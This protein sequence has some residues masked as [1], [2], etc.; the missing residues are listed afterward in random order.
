MATWH[1]EF[2]PEVITNRLEKN[3]TMDAN[4]QVSFHGFEHSEYT[5][6]L[7]SMINFNREIPELER[8]KI[9]NQSIFTAATKVLTHEGLL[10]EISKLEK[11]YLATP[12][13]RFRLV[14]SISMQ[15]PK[16]PLL[17][18]FREHEISF[19]WRQSKAY[20]L[21]AHHVGSNRGHCCWRIAQLL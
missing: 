16:V 8:R 7:G 1:S 19:G 12:K 3:K 13:K 11:S 20:P 4:C 14:T 21:L 6:I 15:H 5:S 18:R 2:K 9:I 17:L 10:T